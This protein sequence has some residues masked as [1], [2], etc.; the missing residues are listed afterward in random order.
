MGLF[1]A[2]LAVVVVLVLAKAWKDLTSI[3]PRT[4][5]GYSSNNI[6]HSDD[7]AVMA[8]AAAVVTCSAVVCVS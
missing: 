2:L 7:A 4:L 5:S 6:S 1:L 3:P 8:S